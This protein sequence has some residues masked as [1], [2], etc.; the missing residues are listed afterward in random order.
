MRAWPK[1][2]R[3]NERGSADDSKA[4]RGLRVGR[5]QP[6]EF[7]YRGDPALVGAHHLLWQ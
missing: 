2:G 1:A 6:M 4:I 3:Y 7:E 5:V